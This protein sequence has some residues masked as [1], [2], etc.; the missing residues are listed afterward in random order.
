MFE[1]KEYFE[2]HLDHLRKLLLCEPRGAVWHNANVILP[3]T[4]PA[5]Q[6]GYIILESTE[7]PAMSDSNTMCVA[8]V[9]LETGMLPI[10]EPVTHLTLES[11]AGLIHVECECRD[12]KVVRASLTNRPAF[13]F[14]D[15][16]SIDVPTVGTLDVAVAHGGMTF[17]MV[18]A[19][20]LGLTLDISEEA[21]MCRIGELIKAATVPAVDTTHPENPRMPGLTNS[22]FMGPAQTDEDASVTASA[23]TVVS[24][25]RLDRSPCGTGTSARLALMH[26]RGELAVNQ[27]LRHVS[28]T[29]FGVSRQDPVDDH[30][31][32]LWRGGAHRIGPC[33]DHLTQHRVAGPLRPVPG[34]IRGR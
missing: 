9:L 22:V 26:H 6:A 3:P 28:A 13:V 7:Y 12:G 20:S 1:K 34:R 16:V 19:A 8:T 11:P 24:P 5:A 2:R 10:S 25:G 33:L 29:G 31:G 14:A 32:P 27:P 4:D 18:D 21:D 15:H 17:A 23:A 30:R